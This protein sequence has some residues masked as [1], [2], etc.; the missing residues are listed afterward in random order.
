MRERFTAVCLGREG[1]NSGQGKLF[2]DFSVKLGGL[3][4]QVVTE[5]CN[6]ATRYPITA[7]PGRVSPLTFPALTAYGVCLNSC[8]SDICGSICLGRALARPIREDVQT[9]LHCCINHDFSTVFASCNAVRF[10]HL[11]NK[12]VGH[13]SSQTRPWNLG[14]C[15]NKFCSS[16]SHSRVEAVE[17]DEV[18]Q[19]S[20][21]THTLS[22][23]MV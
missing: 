23:P 18:L 21:H 12:C 5:F 3:R 2:A 1:E 7:S 15:T 10:C 14:H 4:W 8:D 6:A 9:S 19:W 22:G 20:G 11:N 17:G 16:L 13:G